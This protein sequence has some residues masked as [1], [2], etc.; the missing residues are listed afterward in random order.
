VR[1]DFEPRAEGGSVVSGEFRRFGITLARWTEHAFDF[2]RPERYRVLREYSRGPFVSL[3]GGV[4]LTS[5]GAGT[6]VL[7][8]ARIRPRNPL[9]WLLAKRLVGP[10]STARVLELCQTFEA[11]LRG[12]SGSAFPSIESR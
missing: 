8:Y 1:F 5:H 4:Q 11:Y 12:R 9:G 6:E 3:D 10:S 7:V 2:I